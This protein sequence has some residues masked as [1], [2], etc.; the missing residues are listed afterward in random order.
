MCAGSENKPFKLAGI[1]TE[2]RA[3]PKILRVVGLGKAVELA[4]AELDTMPGQVEGS[5]NPRATGEDS[6]YQVERSSRIACG[7]ECEL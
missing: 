4:E 2:F 3:A 1:R 6:P 5:V 7:D